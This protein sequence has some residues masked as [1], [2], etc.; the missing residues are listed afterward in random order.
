M[1][2][3]HTYFNAVAAFMEDAEAAANEYS[4]L[5]EQGAHPSSLT[6]TLDQRMEDSAQAVLA[7]QRNLA[8]KAMVH[9]VK[10]LVTTGD[11]D[12]VRRTADLWLGNLL[13]DVRVVVAADAEIKRLGEDAPRA[14]ELIRRRNNAAK[15]AVWNGA[16]IYQLA[17]CTGRTTAEVNGWFADSQH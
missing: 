11:V 16:S 3:D 12:N 10:C 5:R 14:A 2:F 4:I 8:D 1:K 9:V 13:V 6:R 7:M 15:T 17:T